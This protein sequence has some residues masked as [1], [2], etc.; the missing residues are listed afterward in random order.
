MAEIL[1][2]SIGYIVFFTVKSSFDKTQQVDFVSGHAKVQMKQESVF[3]V[4][5]IQFLRSSAHHSRMHVVVTRRRQLVPFP[6]PDPGDND[7]VR[8]PSKAVPSRN[9]K[10]HSSLK[11]QFD[12]AFTIALHAYTPIQRKHTQTMYLWFK[13]PKLSRLPMSAWPKTRASKPDA[14]C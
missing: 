12:S 2:R 13:F 1:P 8:S 10:N 11:V 14:M 7:P 9:F 3:T 4:H 6:S 5:A